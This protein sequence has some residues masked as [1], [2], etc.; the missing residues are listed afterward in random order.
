MQTINVPPLDP[1]I[2]T[3]PTRLLA[4]P[5]RMGDVV[6]G[7]PYGEYASW[8]FVGTAGNVSII[9]WDGTTQVL[10]GIPAGWHR[11]GS[12][13][14]NAAGTSALNLVWGS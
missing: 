8:L 11:M 1:H 14:V 6:L 5:T 12:I 9:K 13:G 3:G 7:T 4:G 10:T 2:F